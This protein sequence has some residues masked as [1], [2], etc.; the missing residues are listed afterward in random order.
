MLRC[1][2]GSLYTGMT[3]N[4]EKRL[5]LHNQG[6][7]ARY[8]ASRL[9]VVLVWHCTVM[10]KSAALKEEYRIKQLSRLQK[11]DLISSS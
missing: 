5:T 11:L 4:I 10:D 1:Q 6:K 8:T 9:P 2:D 3:N 7:A